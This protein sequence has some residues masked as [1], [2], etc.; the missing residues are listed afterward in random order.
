MGKTI[1]SGWD[2]RGLPGAVGS[3][4]SM[5]PAALARPV[6]LGAKVVFSFFQVNFSLKIIRQVQMYWPARGINCVPRR[7]KKTLTSIK[8]NNAI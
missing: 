2:Q 1:E 8:N 5:V 6:V 4:I 7:V 3:A